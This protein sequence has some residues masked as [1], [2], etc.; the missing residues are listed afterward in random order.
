M[1]ETLGGEPA[2]CGEDFT[3]ALAELAEMVATEQ[4]L[5]SILKRVEDI[6]CAALAD[7]S[8]ASVT[9]VEGGR[10]TTPAYT[11]NFALELDLAQYEADVGPCLLALRQGTVVHASIADDRWPVFSHAARRHGIQHSMSVPLSVG[12]VTLGALNLYSKAAEG[13]TDGSDQVTARLLAEQAVAALSTARAF[14][15]ERTMAG[16]LQRSVLPDRLPQLAGYQLAGCY[17]PAGSRALVGGDWYDALL[18]DDGSLAIVIGDVAGHG[19]KAA[20]VMGQLK[21]GMR[22]YAL[23]GHDPASC[24]IL[25]SRLL[26]ATD[27][28][29]DLHFAT[30]CL[31]LV[32][33]MTGMCRIA[34]AGHLPPAIRD[35]DGTVRFINGSGGPPLGIDPTEHISD[36]FAQLDPGSALVLFTDGLVEGRH[37]SLDNGLSRFA[38]VLAELRGSADHLCK[39]LADEM[40]GDD[41]QEDDI[42]ILVLLRL[43]SS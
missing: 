31:A 14:E 36:D 28:D 9:L 39:R 2:G 20:T 13:L 5:V 8:G 37:R 11:E 38:A 23:E 15:A 35:A 12:D 29:L 42:A 22:A 40:L 17:L 18:R 32:D 3:S 4:T 24:L 21:T 27:G 34:S 30:A 41:P 19:I 33:P 6:A 26:D 25:L 1:V 7:C 10:P 43:A 16:T